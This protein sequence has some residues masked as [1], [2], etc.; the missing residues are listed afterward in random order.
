MTKGVLTLFGEMIRCYGLR[1]RC[2]CRGNRG[3]GGESWFSPIAELIHYV[4][5]FIIS[6]P[7]SLFPSAL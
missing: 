1:E 3:L 6:P 5:V 7:L 2:W 4:G